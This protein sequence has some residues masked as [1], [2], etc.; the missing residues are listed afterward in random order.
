[1]SRGEGESYQ[2]YLQAI[3]K[4]GFCRVHI[5]KDDP[6]ECCEL[7]TGLTPEPVATV[8]AMAERSERTYARLA[9]IA[10]I[11]CDELSPMMRRVAAKLP[12]T[13]TENTCSTTE[14]GEP[15]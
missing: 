6:P 7:A 15:R 11:A 10:C 2:D 13:A 9:D 4:C 3:L 14:K 12:L 5:R 8:S 1:M